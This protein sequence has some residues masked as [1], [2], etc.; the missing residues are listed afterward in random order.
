[1]SSQ[2]GGLLLT[3]AVGDAG[4]SVACNSSG[5]LQTDSSHSSVLQAYPR[6]DVKCTIAEQVRSCG[7]VC[8][9]FHM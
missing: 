8:V 4:T 5:E 9:C 6:L 7:C 2:T 3:S 1:M